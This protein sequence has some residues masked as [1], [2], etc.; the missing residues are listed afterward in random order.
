MAP[1]VDLK[2]GET[3]K[4]IA[5]AL[6][7]LR[8]GWLREGWKDNHVWPAQSE[9]ADALRRLFLP[10]FKENYQWIVDQ[11]LKRNTA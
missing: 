3:K 7:S 8:D 6:K 2:Q 11:S 9:P 1:R 4:H 5:R 10:F